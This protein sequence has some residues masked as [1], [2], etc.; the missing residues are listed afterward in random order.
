MG[1]KEKGR[2]EVFFS[3]KREGKRGKKGGKKDKSKPSDP[4]VVPSDGSRFGTLPLYL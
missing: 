3:D 4:V 1:K 2:K